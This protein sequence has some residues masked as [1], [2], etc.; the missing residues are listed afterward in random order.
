M[1]NYVIN[2]LG[3]QNRARIIFSEST[4]LAQGLQ[5]SIDIKTDINRALIELIG[6]MCLL[7]GPLD[8]QQRLFVKLKGTTSNKYIIASAKANGDVRGFVNEDLIQN[9][10]LSG[11]INV[12]GKRGLVY[13]QRDSGMFDNYTGVTEMRY[14]SVSK[15]IELYYRQSEQLPTYIR[16]FILQDEKG[17]ITVSRGLMLQ[18]LPGESKSLISRFVNALKTKAELISSPKNHVDFSMLQNMLL[19]DLKL[20]SMKQLNYHCGCTKEIY[21]G[22]IFSLSPGEIDE[23]ILKKQTLKAKCSMCGKTYSFNAVEI[24]RLFGLPEPKE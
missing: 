2:M 3:Y 1:D 12:L 4:S 19:D 15:N 8:N 14:G 7:A 21:Y 6:S 13:V 9:K 10:S 16:L 18:L 22:L 5:D 17:R 11:E 23:I 24:A 20:M